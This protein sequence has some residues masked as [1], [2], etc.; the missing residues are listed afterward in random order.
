MSFDKALAAVEMLNMTVEVTDKAQAY[1]ASALRSPTRPHG[2][3]LGDRF[4]LALAAKMGAPVI[5]TDKAWKKLDLGV[6]VIVAR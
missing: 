3:S 4:C 2:L 1:S 5:T 6:E